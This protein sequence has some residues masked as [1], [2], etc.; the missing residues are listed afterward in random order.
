MSEINLVQAIEIAERYL[1][2]SVRDS[3]NSVQ[4]D[5]WVVSAEK[6]VDCGEYWKFH[7]QSAMYLST[8][9]PSYLLVG[10]LPLRVSK[11]GEV[12]GFGKG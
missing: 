4:G 2:E 12:L 1:N 7:Y 11:T 6:A 5:R 9:N 10:N 8:D 3:F